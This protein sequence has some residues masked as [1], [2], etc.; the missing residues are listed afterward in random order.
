MSDVTN[1]LRR[2]E[3]GEPSAGDELLDVVYDELRRQARSCMAREQPGHTLQGTALV[4]EVYL[5][6]FENISTT[7]WQSRAHFFGAVAE[8]MR[9]VLVDRARSKLTQKRGGM[10]NN[11]QVDFA[12]IAAPTG[13]EQVLAISEALDKLATTAPAAAEL[14]KLRFF[15]GYTIAEAAE[16]MSISP[17]KADRLWVYAKA[18]LSMELKKDVQADND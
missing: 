10:M 18:W 7:K 2:L 15:V 4:H 12:N 14:V 9:R 13:T 1:I 8:V 6:L 17:R 5:R 11:V 16:L 3:A